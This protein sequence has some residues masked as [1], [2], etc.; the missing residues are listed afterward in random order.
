[1]YPSLL[2]DLG[3]KVEFGIAMQVN[4]NPQSEP[5]VFQCNVGHLTGPDYLHTCYATQDMLKELIDDND[6]GHKGYI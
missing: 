6:A 2:Y 1:M 5:T 3:P 4:G